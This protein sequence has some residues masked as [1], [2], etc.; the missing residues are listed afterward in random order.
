MANII[1]KGVLSKIH[2]YKCPPRI[3]GRAKHLKL[4]PGAWK[5]PS[6][7]S[8]GLDFQAVQGTSPFADWYSPGASSLMVP[9]AD[10]K[11]TTWCH[12]KQNWD[13]MKTLWLGGMMKM[14]HQIMFA[15]SENSPYKYIAMEHYKDSAVLVW[16]ATIQSIPRTNCR[17]IV[18]ALDVMEPHL[19][20]VADLSKMVVWHFTYRS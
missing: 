8:R 16:P 4:D 1:K 3:I 9:T 11:T 7:D 5:A 17:H 6:K 15:A 2:K 13:L 19:Q 10:Q 20:L 14:G 12:A 18:P